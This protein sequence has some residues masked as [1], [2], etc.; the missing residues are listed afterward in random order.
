MS[1]DPRIFLEHILESIEYIESYVKDWTE[2]DFL[3]SVEK[4]DSVIRRLEILGEAV[5]NLPEEFRKEHSDIEW[6]KAMATRN[7]LVHHYFGVDLKII[8]D[9]VTQNLPEFKKQILKLLYE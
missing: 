7:I 2:N 4:Q 3:N 8:W 1:K 9:T 6:N 5:K